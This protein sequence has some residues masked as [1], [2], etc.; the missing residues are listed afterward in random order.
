MEALGSVSVII[1][2][3]NRAKSLGAAI[4]SA[5][6][7]TYAVSEILVC[8]DGST[9]NT[10]QVVSEF[11]SK[12]VRF[13]EGPRAGRPAVPRNRGLSNA[14][15]KWIAFLDSDDTWMPEKIEK[16]LLDLQRTGMQASCTNALRITPGKNSASPYL[17]NTE[18]FFTLDT[19]LK[20]NYVV[21]SSCIVSKSLLDITGGF[22]EEEQLR[23][24]EDF[25]LWLRVAT[26]TNFCYTQ[27]PLATYADDATNSIR[28]GIKELE[29]RENVM[30]DLYHWH[31]KQQNG[32]QHHAII[33]KA[34]R[35]AMKNNGRTF[36]QRLKIK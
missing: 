1:P 11:N 9:D 15:G 27:E 22:P 3:W 35:L 10:R 29:Q 28:S 5:L 30:S 24:I 16:Q 6:D 21:C 36:F 25:A 18:S 14:R 12:I 26:I 31:V 8:D 2:T 4:Q 32:T 17:N 19:L 34:Y 13:I 33:R 23:A 7:Q 20:T